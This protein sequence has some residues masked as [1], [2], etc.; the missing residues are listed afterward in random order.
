MEY[1]IPILTQ[2]VFLGLMLPIFLWLPETAQYYAERDMDERGKKTLARINGGVPGYDV[3]TE[4]A[5]IKNN[6]LDQ[7]RIRQELG[8][9]KSVGWEQMLKSYVECLKGVNAKRTL[10]AAAPA[11]AQQLT[12][13][14]FLKTYSSLFFRQAG[15]ADPFLITTVLSESQ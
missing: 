3:E 12:G 6:I 7:R 5:V 10:G 15:F 11:C 1:K 4:Y 8:E 9:D 14:S 13:L 2:W